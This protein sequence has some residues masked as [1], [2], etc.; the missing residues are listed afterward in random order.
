MADSDPMASFWRYTVCLPRHYLFRI[1]VCIIFL[2]LALDVLEWSS[3]GMGFALDGRLEFTQ[4]G[5]N[6]WT[7]RGKHFRLT[8]IHALLVTL[9]NV[10][11]LSASSIQTVPH[12]RCRDNLCLFYSRQS[13]TSRVRTAS[14]YS[15]TGKRGFS[16]QLFSWPGN[17][18]RASPSFE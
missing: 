13:I 9:G 12:W 5:D 2:Q 15:T 10:S 1:P 6:M 7:R 8:T 14:C 17:A 16:R 4:A 3:D 11:T 18:T